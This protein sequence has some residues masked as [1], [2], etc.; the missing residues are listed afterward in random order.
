VDRESERVELDQRGFRLP[1]GSAQR[2]PRRLRRG[3]G[4]P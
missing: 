1:V 2:T 4:M 3:R